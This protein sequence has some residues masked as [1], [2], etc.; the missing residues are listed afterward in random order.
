MIMERVSTLTGVPSYTMELKWQYMN[1]DFVI[2]HEYLTYDNNS[3]IADVGGYLGLLLGYSVLS[4][5][6]LLGNCTCKT[7]KAFGVWNI[8]NVLKTSSVQRI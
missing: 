6:E 1:T 2:R 7:Y 3:F 4:I 5:Y 8:Q